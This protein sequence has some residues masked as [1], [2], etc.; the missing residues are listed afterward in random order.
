[1]QPQQIID[2]IAN[3]QQRNRMN[4]VYT[5]EYYLL[6][7]NKEEEKLILN[8]S[9]STKNVYTVTLDKKEKTMWCNCPDMKSHAARYGVWCKHCCFTL[10]KI[11]RCFEVDYF[12]NAKHITEACF[13]QINERLDAVS[14]S[15]VISEELSNAFKRLNTTDKCSKFDRKEREIGEEDECPI[16]YDYLSCGEIKSCPDCKQYV[17]LLCIQKWLET[18]N[19]CVLCRSTEWKQFLKGKNSEYIQL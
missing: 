7:Y 19:T 10:L 6:D 9:G 2:K 3:V 18:K 16:C 15:D 17:H 8:I 13:T 11:G 14:G 12:M 4:K 1:M 5:E